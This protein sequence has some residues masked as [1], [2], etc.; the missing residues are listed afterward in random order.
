MLKAAFEALQTAEGYVRAAAWREE[1][2][3]PYERAKAV[4]DLAKV[5][6][7]LAALQ[8]EMKQRKTPDEVA[9]AT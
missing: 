1:S 8:I 5:Q 7:A 9:L 3:P 6:A 2:E 4:E